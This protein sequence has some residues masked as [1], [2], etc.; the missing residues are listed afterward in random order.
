LTYQQLNPQMLR[1]WDVESG[2]L[3][4]TIE[5]PMGEVERGI[6]CSP[7]R[8]G[9]FCTRDGFLQLVPLPA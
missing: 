1:L 6:V 2:S 5:W 9:A 3:R 7:A 4:E 8:R